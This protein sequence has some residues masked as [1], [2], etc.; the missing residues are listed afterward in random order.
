M[1]ELHGFDGEFTFLMFFQVFSVS[2][3]YVEHSNRGEESHRERKKAN[4]LHAEEWVESRGQD[5]TY[6][7]TE[8]KENWFCVI[9]LELAFEWNWGV[10]LEQLN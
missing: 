10:L 5:G 9:V 1:P 7:V 8:T 4:M 6:D 2:V 3:L